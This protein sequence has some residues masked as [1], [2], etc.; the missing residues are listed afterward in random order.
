MAAAHHRLT[1]IYE[2]RGAPEAYRGSFFDGPHKF[3][4]AMQR[5]AFAWL[6]KNLGGE[7]G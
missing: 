5:Q 1:E 3:D 6:A 4:L 7:G 2:S